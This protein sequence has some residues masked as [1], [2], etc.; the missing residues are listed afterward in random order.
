MKKLFFQIVLLSLLVLISG[1]DTDEQR[2]PQQDILPSITLDSLD[3]QT[4]QDTTGSE[5]VSSLFDSIVTPPKTDT[6]T[7]HDSTKQQ[8]SEKNDPGTI[9]DIFSVG[10]IIWS[11]IFGFIG[12]YTI[13]FLVFILNKFSE[14]STKY[15]LT[16]K[17]L[18]PIIRIIGWG[19]ILYLI[20]VVIFRPPIQTV[21]LIAGSLGVAV[22]FASQDILKNIFGG[23]VILF[24][25]PFQVGDKVA[26][27]DVYGEVTNI[28]LR[29]IR[30]VTP[31]DSVV[32]I[33]N[34]DIMT[35]AVSNANNGETNCQVVAEFFLPADIDTKKAK[36]IATRAAQV[37]R[38]IY[39]NKPITVLFFNEVQRERIVLK[40]RLKAYVLDIRYEFAFKSE[41]TEIVLKEFI[42]QGIIKH[43]QGETLFN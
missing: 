13:K 7:Q 42:N 15:R 43:E 16:L 2:K 39:L 25:R 1:C 12:F 8:A 24:D 14:K 36:A 28:G 26:I 23:I 35:K 3:T 34:A 22:G 10:K 9:F 31:D 20:T 33:P 37:S 29:S 38:Y 17:G 19:L 40:M 5:T 6:T 32:S 18:I 11:I 30:I 27:D 21:L 4:T 41:M